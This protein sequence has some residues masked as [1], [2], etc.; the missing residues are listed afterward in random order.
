VSAGLYEEEEE[1]VSSVYLWCYRG[2]LWR[3]IRYEEE[4]WSR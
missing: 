3:L 4:T 2:E 1:A